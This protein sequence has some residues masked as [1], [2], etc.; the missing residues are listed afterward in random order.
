MEGGKHVIVGLTGG[1]ATGKSTVSRMLAERGAHIID[2]DQV[3]REVVE[4]HTE[5]WHRIRVRFGEEVFHPDGTLN[6]QA[7]GA[8]V[9]RD[10]A[11]REELNRLLHPLIVE[12]MQILTEQCRA[13]D[14]DGIVVW[15]TPLLIEGNLTKSVEKVIVV[16][17]P[18]WL[19][20]QRLIARDGLS[21][22][23]ARRRIA[24]QLPIE[25]KKRF[26][27]ILIDNSGSLAETERQV[28]QLWKSLNSKNGYDRR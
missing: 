13:R 28:D 1:I 17:I 12:R 19:Q 10:T 6:R 7:L 21:E 24:S 8:R 22:E 5:G 2:A 9:F 4:P 23:E 15:D 25:E 27:D 14:P 26:A 11:A 16:Y 20:L 18:E 3:A